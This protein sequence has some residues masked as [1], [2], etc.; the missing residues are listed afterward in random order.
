MEK[1]DIEKIKQQ[2]LQMKTQV[3]KREPIMKQRYTEIYSYLFKNAPTLFEMV[4]ENKSRYLSLLETM[5]E[6]AK[7]IDKDEISQYDAD[8]KI[9]QVL[10]DIYVH[11]AIEEKN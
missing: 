10:A 7:K 8:V 3:E 4:Y 6:D 2:V 9:G 1:I 11:P 5:M